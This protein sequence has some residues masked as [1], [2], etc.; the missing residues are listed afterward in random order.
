MKVVVQQE[1]IPKVMFGMNISSLEGVLY[2]G[3]YACIYKMGPITGI[4]EILST[5]LYNMN[6]S[7]CQMRAGFPCIKQGFPVRMWAPGIFVF[8]TGTGF[9]V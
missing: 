7:V 2:K 3:M 1:K 9:A 5:F 8:I 6:E 4:Y